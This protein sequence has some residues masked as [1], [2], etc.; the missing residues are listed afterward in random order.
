VTHAM[1]FTR[2]EEGIA[3]LRARQAIK[4]LFLPWAEES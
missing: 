4:V 3:L 2:Y 1:P